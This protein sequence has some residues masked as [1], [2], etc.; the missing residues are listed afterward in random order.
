MYTEAERLFMVQ[1]IKWVHDAGISKG[2]G[3]YDFETDMKELKP[4]I[5]FVNE[6]ASKLDGRVKI[7]ESLGVKMVV[8]PRK[9]NEGLA[10]RSSTSMKARLRD[11][12]AADEKITELKRQ[13]LEMSAFNMSLPWRFC[14]AGGWMDLAWVNEHHEGCAITINIKFNPKICRDYCGLATSSRKV[15]KKLWN[16]RIPFYL[17]AEEAAKL[18]WGAENFDA[19]AT[20]NRPYVA[21]S[22]DHCGLMFPGINKLCYKDGKHW[23]YKIIT[24]NDTQD[25]KQ[26]A[27]F[28]FLEEVLWVV[29]IPFVSRPKGYSSQRINYLKDEKVSREE[30][31]KMV[32]ALAKASENAWNAIINMD[33]KALGAA[34]SAT[35]DAWG[36]MLPFTVNPHH[37]DPEKSKKLDDFRAKYDIP[38]TRGCLFSGAGGGFLLVIDDKP[39]EKGIKIQLN[40]DHYCK[41]FASDK[42]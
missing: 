42:V 41:P 18:L 24:L 23:P 37:G 20:R 2:S 22:Q 32:T 16:G 35:M 31:V 25:S 21:G 30:K 34:L 28:K 26:K 11:M 17:E 27:I 10:I 33:V 29:D 8:A 1:N 40:H 6:D 38:N 36:T 15:A 7:C 39:V 13:S 3:V 19:F 4:D 12:L 9:P 5:Y 14:F